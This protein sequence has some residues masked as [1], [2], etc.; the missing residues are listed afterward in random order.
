MNDTYHKITF[1]RNQRDD[2]C[3]GY[4]E[5]WTFKDMSRKAAF[6]AVQTALTQWIATTDAGRKAYGSYEQFNFGDFLNS[7]PWTD[8]TF[9]AIAHKHGIQSL[10]GRSIDVTNNVED[11]DDQ[12]ADPVEIEIG[13]AEQG[14]TE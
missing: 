13:W 10:D 9:P 7:E 4:L 1:L 14:I 6:E 5:I 8:K 2:V 12:L 3:L 11:W